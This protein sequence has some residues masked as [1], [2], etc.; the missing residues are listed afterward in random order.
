MGDLVLATKDVSIVLL[1]SSHTGQTSQSTREFVS[2]QDTKIGIPD[3]E[4][5]IR[6]NGATKHETMGG[7]VHWFHGPF[8]TLDLEGE[9]IVLVVQRVTG[10]MPKIQIEKVRGD[11]F[12]VST[13]PVLV[14]DKVHELVVDTR[15]MG[16]PKGGSGRQIVE[17]DEFLLVGDASVVAF[18]G[19]L[20]HFLPDLELFLVGKGNSIQP[21]Q[22]IVFSISQ[23]VG[24][25]V[26]GGGKGLDLSGVGQVGTSTEINQISASVHGGTGSI[27]NFRGK[28]LDLEGVVLKHFEGLVLGDDHALEFLFRFDNLLDL[29][30]DGFVIVFFD[31]ILSHI[32]IVVKSSLQWRSNGELVSKQML[33]CFSQHVRRRM[34]KDRLG[35]GI[36]VEL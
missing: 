2:V 7:T 27:G 12:V 3:G 29:F 6:S 17:E 32:R 20:H 36:V 1:E 10:L 35:L 26:L 23:P 8:L 33:Q 19:L 14:L 13:N 9:H 11:D 16:K 25:R 5:T 4:V 21:L 28:N 18:L 22:R 24:G 34:P 30:F 31:R 15:S